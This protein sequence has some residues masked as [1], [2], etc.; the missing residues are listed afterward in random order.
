MLEQEQDD[1]SGVGELD[2][3]I[4]KQ[5]DGCV[6]PILSVARFAPE[7]APD[8]NHGRLFLCLEEI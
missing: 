2:G 5:F 6:L 1:V 3:I 8:A 4:D 7:A